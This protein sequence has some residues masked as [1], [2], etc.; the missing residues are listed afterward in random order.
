MRLYKNFLVY[1]FPVERLLF[2]SEVEAIIMKVLNGRPTVL[3]LSTE[4]Q[5]E[6]AAVENIVKVRSS[7]S[8]IR[9][10]HY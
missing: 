3:N 10:F 9:K 6:P 2:S 7:A 8:V 5:V 4:L 1:H